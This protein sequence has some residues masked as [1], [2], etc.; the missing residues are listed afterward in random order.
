MMISGQ[1]AVSLAAPSAASSAVANKDTMTVAGRG[2][3][4]SAPVPSDAPHAGTGKKDFATVAKEARSAI[5]AA[6]ERLGKE[7]G[8]SLSLQERLSVFAT[9]DRRSLYAVA[10]NAGGHFSREERFGA[11]D[12]MELQ[13]QQAR[14]VDP[15]NPASIPTTATGMAAA[16]KA[17]ITFLDGV[18]DE[19]KG[20][21]TWAAYRAT[22]QNFYEAVSQGA[23]EVPE[24]LDSDN[25]LVKVLKA[26]MT[27]ARGDPA[28]DRTEG[29]MDT[30]DGLKNQPWAKGFEVQIDQA[31]RESARQGALIDHKV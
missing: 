1:S 27:V 14:G 17:G 16:S 2:G 9:M 28:R 22:A 8:A 19:E 3:A 21:V 18:S 24:N 10:S 12:A 20:S 15:F 11:E 5:D 4:A 26:A 25:P 31:F 13:F 29:R 30:L 7:N 23:G 6:Y